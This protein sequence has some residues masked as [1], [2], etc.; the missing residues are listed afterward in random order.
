MTG[1]I[2]AR[3]PLEPLHP[4]DALLA[5]PFFDQRNSGIASAEATTLAR[6]RH[7]NVEP[8]A[9]ARQMNEAS[10][11]VSASQVTENLLLNVAR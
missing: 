1:H 4:K 10:R 6:K 7:Q 11:E 8:A 5:L 3:E 2:A 9:L